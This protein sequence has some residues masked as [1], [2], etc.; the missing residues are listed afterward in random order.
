VRFFTLG[1]DYR[2]DQNPTFGKRSKVTS[3][4]AFVAGGEK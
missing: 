2:K 1:V 3:G 4:A